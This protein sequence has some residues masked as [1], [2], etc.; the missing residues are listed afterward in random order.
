MADDF[1]RNSENHI[2]TLIHPG[3][4]ENGSYPAVTACLRKYSDVLKAMLGSKN[5]WEVKN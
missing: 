4:R 5:Q 3:V 1:L 2:N